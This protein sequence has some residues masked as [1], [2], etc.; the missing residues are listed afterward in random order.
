VKRFAKIILWSLGGICALVI[1]GLIGINLYLQS[2]DVQQRI[3]IA[4]E[5]AIGAPLSI[6]RTMFT[7]WTGLIL[8]GLTMPDPVMENANM[9][10]A[11]SFSMKFEFLP[12][13][14]KQFII[15]EITLSHP[16]LVL[17][18]NEKGKWVVRS[19]ELEKP[20]EPPQR[21]ERPREP[22]ETR[23]RRVPKFE[24]ELRKFTIRDGEGTFLDRKGRV[25]ARFKQLQIDGRLSGP[26]S[27]NGDIWIE[28]IEL[29]GRLFPKRLRAHF[30]QEGT[31]LAVT[32][33]KAALA[34]GR[35]RATFHL[36]TPRGGG[37]SEF[38]FSGEVEDVSIPKLIAEAHGDD[39]NTSGSIGGTVHLKGNPAA[40]ESITGEGDF[41]LLE[42]KLKPLDAIQ[43]IGSLLRIDELQMLDLE[44]AEFHFDV[45]DE[46]VWV[47]DLTLQTENVIISGEGPVKFS[48]ELD[49]DGRLMIS[50]K[51]QENLAGI[52]GDQF[53]PSENAKYKQVGFFVR[54]RLDRPKTNL[55]EKVTGL[56]PS[57]GGFL[58]GL[59]QVTRPDKKTDDKE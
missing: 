24:V 2:S 15:S 47:K 51:L 10:E 56:P 23:E 32:N 46:A 28:E 18:Q 43:K 14:R 27:A 29:G 17:R 45:H 44:Q 13:F 7:P 12:L 3:R 11:P 42:A 19:E 37:Q 57:V 40:S 36:T 30:E 1:L 41:A 22:R 50:E 5:R 9:L 54:G 55:I 4:T 20:E 16:Q 38:E 52:I 48:G 39:A 34:G 35:I 25:V 53:E 33:V 21:P 59:L 31:H 26:S 49:L 58:K 8:S 6:H